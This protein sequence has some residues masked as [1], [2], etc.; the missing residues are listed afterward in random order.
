MKRLAAVLLAGICLA[1]GSTGWTDDAA[2]LVLEAKLMLGNVKGRVDHFAIDVGRQRL[3]VAELGN[4]SVGVLDLNDGRVIR[5]LSGLREPQ[6]VGY[7]A[8]SDTLYVANAGDGS[9]RLYNGADLSPSGR[10]DLGDDSDNIRIDTR[11]NRV[12]VGYGTG[13]LAVI[14]P[15]TNKK[16]S[17]V[18]LKAH[19]EAF[20]L[21][22]TGTKVFV[23]VPDARQ[24]AVIDAAAGKQALTISPE[25]ARSN[26]PMAV[27]DDQHRV[28]VGF[29]RPPLLSVFSSQDGKQMSTVETCGDADDVFVDLKRHRVYVSCGEGVIDVLADR[30]SRYERVARIPTSS[31]ARTSLFV[32]ERDRLY[33]AVRATLSEPAAVWVF[34]PTP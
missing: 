11:R 9:V 33:L 4:D 17:D 18:P 2:P 29:R 13:A 20:Q 3:Y 1:Y 10:I 8:S 30:G 28:L 19:P 12:L 25:D 14:D 6:G 23:N 21:A 24:I 16:V 27:D 34:R 22:E 32:P 15:A 7:A 5:T 26:F 31:G